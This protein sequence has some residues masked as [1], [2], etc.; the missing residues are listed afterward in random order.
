MENKKANAAALLDDEIRPIGKA[1]EQANLMLECILDEYMRKYTL[2]SSLLVQAPFLWA[3]FH[4]PVKR[5]RLPFC[6]P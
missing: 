5:R 3:E 1:L 6:F 4:H 2:T